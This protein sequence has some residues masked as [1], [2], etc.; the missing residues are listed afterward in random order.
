MMNRK[1]QTLVVILTAAL[2]LALPGC[3]KNSNPD[4]PTSPSGTVIS[5][6]GVTCKFKVT[7]SDT[8]YDRVSVRIDWNNGDTSDWTEMFRSGDTMA[9]EYAWPAA[10]YFR[11]SAQAKDEKGAVSAWSNWHAVTI[12]DTVNVPPENPTVPVG[13]DTGYID[14]TCEFSTLAGDAN[15]D[16]VFL[17]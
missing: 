8:D 13:P 17:Q 2:S 7:A 1:M 14:S 12:A 5:K 10:G 15:G 4:T 6:V 9:L 3:T 11:I 16:R